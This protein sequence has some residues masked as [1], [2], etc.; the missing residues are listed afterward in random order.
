[1]GMLCFLLSV[2][3]NM[4]SPLKNPPILSSPMWKNICCT[5]NLAKQNLNFRVT[6]NSMVFLKW[7]HWCGSRSICEFEHHQTLLNRFPDNAPLNVLIDD[8]G[9]VIPNGCHVDI[10]NAITSIPILRNGN[11]FCLVW[12]DGKKTKKL[13][14]FF[15]EIFL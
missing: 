5:T 7:D 1:M 14:W 15:C 3:L 13:F 12:V 2:L 6:D 9:W 8:I 4:V 11:A 10:F